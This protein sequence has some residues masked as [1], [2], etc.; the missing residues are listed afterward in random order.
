M[1]PAILILG[2]CMNLI[3][4]AHAARAVATFAGGCF[5]CMEPPFDKLEG[6]LSTTSGYTGG[7]IKN[8]TYK[9]VSSGKTGH[10]EAIQV[11]FDPERI[12]YETLLQTF[13]KNIDPMD[14]GGQ[15]CDRGNQ[16]RAAIFYHS[17]E[18]QQLAEAS[19]QTLAESKFKHQSMTTEITQASEFYPAETYHQDY[20]LKNPLRYTFYRHNCG[21]DRILRQYWKN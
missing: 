18:Q 6:V 21:R 1:K 5:W 8:P 15:F 9:Q 4:H 2:L 13:W 7:Y 10:T 11:V 17:P 19:K 3:S 12:S 20:Y 16:Y 14:A